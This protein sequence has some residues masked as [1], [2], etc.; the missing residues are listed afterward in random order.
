MDSVCD[1]PGA[2]HRFNRSTK[3]PILSILSILSK[4]SD[5]DM[6]LSIASNQSKL[7]QDEQDLQ[8]GF[9]LRPAGAMLA[10]ELKTI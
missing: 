6:I 3:L 8:D 2:M 1:R 5:V 4:N 7:R 10:L 9:G